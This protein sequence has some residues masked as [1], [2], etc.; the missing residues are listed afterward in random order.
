MIDGR[1]AVRAH[2]ADGGMGSV[3]VADD[4]RLEREVALKV[5]RP[6][7]ARDPQFVARFRREAL[8]AARLNHPHVV[9][10]SDQ[11]RDGQ[12]VF[13]AMELVSGRTLRDIITAGGTSVADAF[14]LFDQLLDGLG[15]AHAA[16]L[17]HRDIKPEN[18][19]IGRDGVVKVADF[20]LARAVSSPGVTVDSDVLLG[21]ASYL[22]PEQVEDGRVGPRSD[23]YAAGV[24]LFE[25]LT[26]TKAFDGGTPLQIAYRHVHSEMPRIGGELGAHLDPLLA[27]VCA[28]TPDER[29]EDARAL[30]R[31][32]AAVRAAM[33]PQLLAHRAPAAPAPP[34]HMGATAAQQALPDGLSPDATRAYGPHHTQAMP[35]APPQRPGRRRRRWPWVAGVLTALAALALAGSLFFGPLASHAVPDVHAQP[36]GQAV[37][38]MRDAGFDV[39]L[40]EVN[41][42]DTPAGQVVRSDPAAGEKHRDDSDVT[43]FVSTGPRMVTV[44]TVL[45][46]TQE[47]AT[48]RVRDAG[49][50]LGKVTHQHRSRPAGQVAASTPAGG[51]KVRHDATVDLVISDGP[52]EVDVPD[53]TGADEQQARSTLAGAGLKVTTTQQNDPGVEKGKVISTSPEANTTAHTGDTVTLTISSG[54]EMVEVPDVVGQKAGRARS[55]LEAAGF[56]VSGGSWFENL[57]DEEVTRQSP[58]GGSGHQAPKGSTVNLS[59]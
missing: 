21:T 31:D 12:F 35:V 22:A 51:A 27:R 48:K 10:V 2:L 7:L 5:L 20:G 17:V 57:L 11:G 28:K 40:R 13:L 59:F 6:D 9:R 19:L 18:V 8:S 34:A 44:P 33:S 38:T 50:T 45:G 49:L 25:L 37:S 4:I 24:V 53:V 55:I 30:R 39:T 41:S 1:Y 58:E 15:A 56:E 52:A 42:D 29:P 23:V 47:Q 14:A 26:G 46:S 43:L 3:F 54:P 32:M 36:Q 16:G